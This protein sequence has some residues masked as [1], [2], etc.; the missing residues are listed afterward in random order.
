MLLLK[1]QAVPPR[2]N[3][4]RKDRP[5]LPG[6]RHSR[7]HHLMDA[8]SVHTTYGVLANLAAM[9]VVSALVMPAGLLAPVAMPFGFDG[10]FWGFVGKG[11]AWLIAVAR[12]V[13]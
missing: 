4:L 1:T 9:P 10:F 3:P 12:W 6:R 8:V 2:R 7:C 13:A 11:I 5:K